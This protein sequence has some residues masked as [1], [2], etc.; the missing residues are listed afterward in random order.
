M[1]R[2]EWV[3]HRL[4]NWALWKV[5]ESSGG[6][7]YSTQSVFLGDGPSDAPAEAW[8]PVDEIDASV[9]N[10]A[11]ESLKLSRPKLYRVLQCIYPQGLGVNGTARECECSLS[12]VSALLD[13]ADRV[14]SAWFQDHADRKQALREAI[15]KSFTT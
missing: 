9:T 3:K 13:V 12:N 8:I 2:I 11:V 1:A 5:R 14:L 7:G 4:N 10:D 6:L 15:R